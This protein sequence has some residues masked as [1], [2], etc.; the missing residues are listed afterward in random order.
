MSNLQ[1]GQKYPG[2]PTGAASVYE[3]QNGN[4][5]LCMEIDVQGEMLRYYAAIATDKDGIN[6]KTVERLKAMFGW[7]GIDPFWFVDNG[8]AYAEREVEATIELKQ[9]TRSDHWF[10]NIKYLDQPGAGSGGEMPQAGNR[11]GL[12]AKYGSKFRAIAGGVPA[13]KPSAPPVQKTMPLAPPAPPAKP[14]RKSDQMECW[15]KYCEAGGTE[16][17][18]F[19]M[20][21]EAVP[22][23]DQGDLTP[24]QWGLVL[25]HIE[26][27]LLRF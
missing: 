6:T 24:V 14:A 15:S 8:A 27:N 18:W 22:G 21:A 12:L 13:A 19:K 23:V 26:T 17:D 9:G 4:L 3:N 20:L 5:V 11:A 7:D 1:D 16:A 10:A 25:D 2:R